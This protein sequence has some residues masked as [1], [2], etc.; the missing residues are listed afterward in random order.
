MKGCGRGLLLHGEREN[1]KIRNRKSFN[2]AT[3]VFKGPV[4]LSRKSHQ[5]VDANGYIGYHTGDV[6]N[7]VSVML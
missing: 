5:Y 3:C 7:Q 4:S 1:M 2:Q 6:V